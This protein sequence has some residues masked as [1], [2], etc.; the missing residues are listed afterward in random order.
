[1][2]EKEAREALKDLA[3]AR[4]KLNAISPGLADE[5]A[6]LYRAG[7]YAMAERWLLAAIE[8]QKETG[9]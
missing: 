3:L 2:T 5:I 6:T 9:P 4:E 8:T 7:H 1:M